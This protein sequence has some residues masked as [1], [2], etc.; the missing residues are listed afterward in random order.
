MRIALEAVSWRASSLRNWNPTKAAVRVIYRPMLALILAKAAAPPPIIMVNAP[1]L[2][3]R[4]RSG[5]LR[6]GAKR[7]PEPD[8]AP[9]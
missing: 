9:P 3:H 1:A 4:S 6:R 5:S 7:R 8:E 2:R